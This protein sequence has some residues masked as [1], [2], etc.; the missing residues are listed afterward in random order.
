M[1]FLNCV[2]RG[3]EL[4]SF[5]RALFRLVFSVFFRWRIVGS[6]NIPASGGAIIAANHISNW[7]PPVIGTA[8]ARPL[9]F[10]AKEELFGNA[11]LRRIIT[12]LGAFPVRRGAADRNAIRTA[13]TL[14]E[15][16]KLLGLFPEGTRSKSG[17]LGEPE[18]GLAMIAIKTGVPVVPAAIIG[19]NRVFSANCWFP[20]FE[21]HFAKP[22]PVAQGK[23]TKE[24]L[25]QLSISIMEAIDTLLKNK[26]SSL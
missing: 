11:V 19:T 24:D 21:V 20:R 14:L 12:S 23:A 9:H 25:A 26:S 18:Q 13:I 10:M 4:Y 1:K 8:I 17:K 15:E 5:V 16:G 2:R 3:V 6:E 22:I 7:D